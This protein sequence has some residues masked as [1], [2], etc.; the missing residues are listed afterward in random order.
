M[1]PLPVTEQDNR[2]IVTCI[3]YMTKWVEAKPLPD[4]SVKQLA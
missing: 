2:Y 1:G 3:D 4:K